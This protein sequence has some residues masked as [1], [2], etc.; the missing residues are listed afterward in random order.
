MS[1]QKAWNVYRHNGR[2]MNTVFYNKRCEGGA[3]ITAEDV[4]HD[5]VEHDGYPPDIKVK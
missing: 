5:L 4:Y 3:L 1:K 2:W